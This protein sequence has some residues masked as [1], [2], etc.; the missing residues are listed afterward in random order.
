MSEYRRFTGWFLASMIALPVI[1]YFFTPYAYNTLWLAGVLP[2]GPFWRWY[3]WL[4]VGLAV[5]FLLTFLAVRRWGAPPSIWVVAVANAVLLALR[6]LVPFATWAILETRG[7]SWAP[8]RELLARMVGASPFTTTGIYVSAALGYL[9]AMW[10]GSWLAT[11]GQRVAQ[12]DPEPAS[13]HL[14]SAST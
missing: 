11:R 4:G 5:T 7:G 12:Q 2:N 1:E 13:T 6:P 3:V 10:F 14:T 9:A 8:L